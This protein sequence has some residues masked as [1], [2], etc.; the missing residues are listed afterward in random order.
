MEARWRDEEGN[1]ESEKEMRKGE[2]RECGGGGE[3][4]RSLSY[5]TLQ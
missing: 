1:E 5:D 3:V 4:E 2:R